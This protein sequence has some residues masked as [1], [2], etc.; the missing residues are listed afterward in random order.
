MHGPA[1]WGDWQLAEPA[2]LWPLSC[3]PFDN[4][5]LRSRKFASIR[6]AFARSRFGGAFELSGVRLDGAP[7]SAADRAKLRIEVRCSSGVKGAKPVRAVTRGLGDTVT[8][9]YRWAGRSGGRAG[10]PRKRGGGGCSEQGAMRA[11]T[12]DEGEGCRTRLGQAAGLARLCT[13]DAVEEGVRVGLWSYI[14]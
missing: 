9:F 1:W 11:W 2:S 8:A 7:L 10:S 13:A 5:T 3:F 14:E 4:R 6:R 12:G